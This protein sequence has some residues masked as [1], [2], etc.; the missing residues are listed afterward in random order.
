MKNKALAFDFDGVFVNSN[1]LKLD[2]ISKEI[3]NT[4]RSIFKSLDEV[5]T[6]V[7]KNFGAGRECLVKNAFA[8]D[9]DINIMDTVLGT[10]RVTLD[11][12][13]NKYKLDN[14]KTIEKQLEY[15]SNEYALYIVSGASTYSIYKI[16]G[17]TSS[18]F[19]GILSTRAILNKEKYLNFIQDK[20]KVENFVGDAYGDYIA[21]KNQNIPFVFIYGDAICN[22]AEAEIIRKNMLNE[23]YSFINYL[24]SIVTHGAKG[25]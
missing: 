10:L 9:L 5:E 24:D 4:K 13:Y 16:L 14:V 19:D 21:A 25:H 7:R 22:N 17:E 23:Y 18:Y 11:P 2:L 8:K 1:R 6:Y 15:L 20:Y 3:F 12:L